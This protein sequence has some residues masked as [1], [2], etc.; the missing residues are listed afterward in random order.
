MAGAALQRPS[1]LHERFDGV[2][3]VGTGEAFGGGFDALDDRYG[4]EFGAEGGVLV[5]H[6]RCVV[7]GGGACGVCGV[8]FLPEEFG[9]AEEGPGAEFPPHYVGP[10]VYF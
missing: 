3:L 4:E 2:G 7:D 5:E 9:G 8:S 1:V 10:L 6:G